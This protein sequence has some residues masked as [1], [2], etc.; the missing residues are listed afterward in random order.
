M[1]LFFH[2]LLS[3]SPRKRHREQKKCDTITV[4]M[5]AVIIEVCWGSPEEA[6]EPFLSRCQFVAR[7]LSNLKFYFTLPAC[8]EL[9]RTTVGLIDNFDNFA[10]LLPNRRTSRTRTRPATR[11]A[12]SASTP[13]SACSARAP[14]ASRRRPPRAHPYSFFLTPTW[15]G[16]FQLLTF[17]CFS[18]TLSNFSK[19]IF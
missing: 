7:F 3:S 10:N 12:R 1:F 4:E 6:V 8:A 16:F 15:N 5:A 13:S 18:V 14:A 9:E 11:R 17:F 19:N 2:R